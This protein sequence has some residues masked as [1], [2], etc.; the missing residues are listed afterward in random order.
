MSAF[1]GLWGLTTAVTQRV[2]RHSQMARASQ[3]AYVAFLASIPFAFVLISII[4]LVASPSAYSSLID[5][6]APRP[7]AAPRSDR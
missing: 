1:A 6:A 2:M 5:R 7:E 3:F 4:G